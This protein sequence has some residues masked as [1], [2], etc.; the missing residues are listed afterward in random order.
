MQI[1]LSK[2]SQHYA[3]KSGE[4]V[5]TLREVDLTVSPGDATAVLGSSGSGKSTLLFI[6]GCMLRP[7]QGEVMID[8]KIV[9]RLG[10]KE[11]AALR[12]LKIGF[13]LQQGFLLPTL[14]VWE[15]VMLP[16]WIGGAKRFNKNETN[17]KV[18]RLLE[19]AGILERARFLPHQLS[20]GQKR[21]AAIVRALVNDPDLIL[22]D[23]PT[24][25]LDEANRS[26][27]S[28]WLL[29]QAEEGKSVVI[30][31]HDPYLANFATRQY[32]LESGRLIKHERRRQ[33]RL[34]SEI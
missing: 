2:V 29:A 18:K 12:S 11:L 24:A 32:S 8:Q 19:E 3:G 5:V 30:A 27:V 28:R 14:T 20:G 34:L 16:V 13:I 10:E 22:A 26:L 9:S 21:R 25:E 31:T 15:N 4:A 6:L 17:H 7:S 1:I 33:N 23:E